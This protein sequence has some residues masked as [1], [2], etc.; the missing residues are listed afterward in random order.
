MFNSLMPYIETYINTFQVKDV[1]ETDFLSEVAVL[2]IQTV[3][4]EDIS[5]KTAGFQHICKIFNLFSINLR[6]TF[7]IILKRM[8][9]Q[10]ELPSVRNHM[11]S[12]LKILSEQFSKEV[13]EQVILYPGDMLNMT[14]LKYYLEVLC[15]LTPNSE[16]TIFTLTHLLKECE[17]EDLNHSRIGYSAL[18]QLLEENRDNMELH[19]ILYNKFKVIENIVIHI[20]RKNVTEDFELM[21]INAAICRMII[22]LLSVEEQSKLVSEHVPLLSKSLQEDSSNLV[23]TIILLEGLLTTL[24]I[25]VDVPDK[26][27]ILKTLLPYS[28]TLQPTAY[29]YVCHIIANFINKSVEGKL[30]ICSIMYTRQKL[31]CPRT[32]PFL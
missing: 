12:C 9:L 2:C 26:Y 22:R 23:N 11:L 5:L 20:F 13:T 18:K 31:S 7:Y 16:F 15:L 6:E 21:E 17:H 24:R 25:E 4:N 27:N 29:A 19:L 28:A 10:E 32:I 8:L 3:Q 14:N 1:S 30:F